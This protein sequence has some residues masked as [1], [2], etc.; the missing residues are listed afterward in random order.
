M[1]NDDVSVRFGAEIDASV[2]EA[3]KQ[4]ADAIG[5]IPEAAKDAQAQ[6]ATAFDGMSSSAR[7][8]AEEIQA[9]T[10]QMN[11]G[12][13]R[14]RET[15]ENLP[16]GATR[17][18]AG[19]A[20]VSHS[21]TN[22]RAIMESL[23]LVHEAMSGR[24]TRLAGSSLI[25]TQALAGEE[26]IAGAVALALSPVGLAVIAVTGATVAGAVIAYQYAEAQAAVTRA[27]VGV[28]AASG[29][30]AEQLNKLAEAGAAGFKSSVGENREALEAFT[31]AGVRNKTT[32]AELTGSVAD[33]A[34]LTGQKAAPAVAELAKAMAD[35]AKGAQDLNEKFSFLDATQLRQIQTMVQLGD[36]MGAQA[37]LAH[38]LAQR[39]DEAAKAAGGLQN[40]F[41]AL[42]TGAS[43]LGNEIGKLITH[44]GDLAQ[45]ENRGYGDPT[46]GA[47]A[48]VAAAQ[49]RA[50]LKQDSAGGADLEAATPEAQAQAQKTQ[51]QGN[52][53]TVSKA[54]AADIQLYGPH[55]DAVKRDSEALAEYTRALNTYVAPAEKAHEIALL[56]IKIA[57][58]KNAALKA[59]LET[60]KEQIQL[61]G[62]VMSSA[63]AAQRAQDA[64]ALKGAKTHEP[65]A[66]DDYFSVAQAQLEQQI[67]SEKDAYANR[68]QIAE[69]FWAARL[70]GAAKSA[71]DQSKIENAYNAARIEVQ[72]KTDAALLEDDK[73]AITMAKESPVQ[74]TAAWAKYLAD[75]KNIYHEGSRE[76]LAAQ[77]ENQQAIDATAAKLREVQTQSYDRAATSASHS[78]ASQTNTQDKALVNQEDAVKDQRSDGQISTAQEVAALT[79]LNQQRQILAEQ[80]AQ[81]ELAIAYTKDEAIKSE[82]GATQAEIAA[83]NENELDAW[84]AYQDHRTAIAQDAADRQ[85]A[86]TQAA[87]KAQEQAYSQAI[88]SMVS[89][90]GSGFLGMA[91]GTETFH[92]VGLKV[93]EDVEDQFVSGAEK[94]L[95][96]WLTAE[97]IK[98]AAVLTG[99]ATQTGAVTAG[100]A[101][102][103][104]IENT[105]FFAK[106]LSLLG[107]QVATQTVTE[108]QKTAAVAAGVSARSTAEVTAQATA[109]AAT[110][111]IIAAEAASLVGLAGAGGVASMAMAP[112]PLDLGAPAFGAAMAAAATGYAT[113][114]SAKGG[115]WQVPGDGMMTELH[116][117]EMVLPASNAS[118]LRNM[119][120]A[121][122]NGGDG[123]GAGGSGGASLSDIHRELRKQTATGA[124]A[125]ASSRSLHSL[126]KRA[127]GKMAS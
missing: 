87:A 91:R 24:F 100:V 108:A 81:K 37:E 127:L 98:A 25:L 9:Q 10:F 110:R 118:D 89:T 67:A 126:G 94:Q 38:L 8:A 125:A 104:A 69:Q 47:K 76:L 35:P 72:K 22:N 33:F 53:N 32:L 122:S 79:A 92:Q 49:R 18:A 7:S 66:R 44:L 101:Q 61:S 31:G 17:A 97:A 73:Y 88:G 99:Q 102:R 6:V 90:V 105:G 83:A 51:L 12:F 4:T 119:M 59:Q 48:A 29:V 19:I 36:K 85:T 121:N 40:W 93:A 1:A 2:S 62:Q 26:A 124:G 109:W 14:L 95:T 50:Q 28:G 117:D 114:A 77:R 82:A 96:S 74:L 41:H 20:N 34:A 107:I 123:F 115:W 13:Q 113:I 27:V 75:V 58:T 54:L 106:I 23:V 15:L 65:K 84:Q 56:D 111:P 30:S 46:A 55:S 39:T 45:A 70:V 120:A 43:D 80:S 5:I 60:Q 64:G 78:N 3:T 42:L 21:G 52:V 103:T 57:S 112:F 11:I 86:I 71:S 116:K 63:E 16:S 68:A